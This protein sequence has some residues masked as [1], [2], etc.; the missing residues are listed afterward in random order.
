MS[1]LRNSNVET[2]V[3]EVAQHNGLVP[4]TVR[5]SHVSENGN[6]HLQTGSSNNYTMEWV[7]CEIPTSKPM[8]SRSP[9]TMDMFPT[10]SDIPK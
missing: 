4:D 6:L 9:N 10:L 5:H 2:H 3:F 1:Y 7:I 8:F